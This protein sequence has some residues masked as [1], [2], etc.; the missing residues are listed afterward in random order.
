MS[1][2]QDNRTRN[3]GSV[4]EY[5]LPWDLEDIAGANPLEERTHIDTGNLDRFIS[6]FD[7]EQDGSTV[8]LGDGKNI[9]RMDFYST[10]ETD[11]GEFAEVDARCAGV[12]D[13]ETY[14][15]LKEEEGFDSVV[16]YVAAP[17]Y[18]WRSDGEVHVRNAEEVPEYVPGDGL[19]YP[20]EDPEP[21]TRSPES[22]FAERVRREVMSE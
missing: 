6:C 14:T 22:G 18:T 11:I 4:E 3:R 9:Y 20:E 16:E 12:C 17:E 5:S 13:P 8:Y 19:V 7:A 2:T 21:E 1:R 10:K 15:G